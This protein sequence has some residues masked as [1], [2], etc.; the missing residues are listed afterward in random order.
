MIHPSRRL[1]VLRTTLAASLLAASLVSTGATL[2][3]AQQAQAPIQIKVA[4]GWSDIVQA[5]AY[6][7]MVESFNKI[8]SAIHVTAIKGVGDTNVLPE[9]SAGDPPDVFVNFNEADVAPWGIAGYALDLDPYIQQ[10]H[11]NTN[12]LIPGARALSVYNGH[13][14]AIPMLVD[15][16]MLLINT[17]LFK[18]AGI[19]KPPTTI[20]EL[21]ADAL[22]L[23]KK[24]SAGHITQL[25]FAPPLFGGDFSVTWFP[26]YVAMFGGRLASA[27]GKTITA[28]C[29]QCVQALQWEVNLYK[30]I[31]PTEIDRFLS[32][33][34]QTEYSHGNVFF[35]GKV[36]MVVDGEY[37][38]NMVPAYAPKGFQWE[39]VPLPYPAGHPELANSG[40]DYG[41][42]AM[43]MK[44]TKN[45]EAAFKVL[46]YMTSVGPTVSLANVVRNVPQIYA[47]LQSP[48]LAKD[49]VY[50][51]F[52]AYAQGPRMTAFPVLPVSAAYQNE[53]GQYEDLALHGKMTAQAALDKVTKDMQTQ[54]DAQQNGL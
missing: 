3:H 32:N 51:R 4:A 27:D 38:T 30:A 28:N 17:K 35:Q 23:T 15:T 18:E 9:V 13:Y 45:P 14:Y 36:A 2:S 19:S 12:Q 34:G 10:A 48:N 54:L 20:E 25:G 29:P 26:V 43:I 52:I 33:A 24:D 42:P 53:L 8:Q 7:R 6:V 46:E 44:G 40:V 31:G 21:T 50:R 16:E 47:A 49:P 5:P 41:N 39:N 22:K 11:Y 37:Y 1:L